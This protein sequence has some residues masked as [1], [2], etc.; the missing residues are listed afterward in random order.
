MSEKQPPLHTY[1]VVKQIGWQGKTYLPDDTVEMLE[2]EALF[3]VENE[4]LKPATKTEA[5]KANK[6]QG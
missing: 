4:V 5:T 6:E 3:F 2:V 1:K